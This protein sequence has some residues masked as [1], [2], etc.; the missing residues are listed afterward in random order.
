MAPKAKAPVGTPGPREMKAGGD[1]RSWV[2]AKANHIATGNAFL[3][4]M[5]GNTE[6][7]EA[8]ALGK[9]WGRKWDDVPEQ[10]KCSQRFF[11]FF[12]TYIAERHIISGG[13]N[14][15]DP[16][17]ASGTA[18]GIFNGLLQHTKQQYGTSTREET[19]VRSPAPR[20]PCA[21]AQSRALPA[22]A[23]DQPSDHPPR[24]PQTFLK[25]FEET[26]DQAAWKK[27]IK[28]KIERLCNMRKIRL[29][30]SLD[31]S[32]TEIFLPQ[33]KELCE[34]LA[35]AN[36]KEAAHRKLAI[37]T[38]WLSAGRSS[39]PGFLSY[40]GLKWNS[41]HG[42]CSV[43]AFQSKPNKLK[44]FCTV[45]G[46]DRQCDFMLHFGDYLVWDRGMTV[47]DDEAPGPLLPDLAGDN[48]GTKLSN[49]IKGLQPE[50][51]PGALKKYTDVGCT[52]ASLPPHPTAAGFRP[53]AA[54]TLAIAV[55][56]ELAVHNT[57]HDLTGLSALWEYLNTR[58]SLTI[59]G[60]VVLAGWPPFPYG[61][62]GKGP[63]HPTL[64]ALTGLSSECFERFIDTLFSFAETGG[65]H[66][67]MLLRDGELRIMLRAVLAT[68]IMY[69]EERFLN[70]EMH[71]VLT[72]MR[73]SYAYA[74]GQPI[75]TAHN[76][77]I[78]WGAMINA[79]FVADNLHLTDRRG[80]FSGAEKVIAAVQGLGTS[81]AVIQRSVADMAGRQIA[82]ESKLDKLI[83]LLSTAPPSA[84]APHPSPGPTIHSSP[85]H[86]PG[87]DNTLTTPT[88]PPP[89]PLP[90][91]DI[92]S[93][94]GISSST[95]GPP[96]KPSA[97]QAAYSLRQ[98][99]AGQFFMDCMALG[100]F[101]PPSVAADSRR[102]TDAQRVLSAYSSMAT[103]TE[104]DLLK[105]PESDAEQSR[106]L[107]RR[108]TQ[109]LITRIKASYLACRSGVPS[110]FGSGH[111]Y[112]N[113]AIDNLRDSK[114]VIDRGLF[115]VWR[116]RVDE[117]VEGVEGFGQSEA[118]QEGSASREGDA[119]ACGKRSRSPRLAEQPRRAYACEADGVSEGE[120]DG[121][122][123]VEDPVVLE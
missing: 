97:L 117:G 49:Y 111:F 26:G 57:G 27:S 48:S 63:I 28:T 16:H 109:L 1:S 69:Y 46:A 60:L 81:I 42:T 84:T 101:F 59:P 91:S 100:G 58:V 121:G 25:C 2:S 85:P 112:F 110:T 47:W 30:E 8:S 6:D 34:V 31:N 29:D 114:L 21:C 70:S 98:L 73:E 41:L 12:A 83:S 23:L 99:P 71:T 77:L 102:K 20:T 33:V 66:P 65:R 38:L 68:M 54:D 94:F 17:Y 89:P 4:D 67:P 32:A 55:P 14:K 62:L 74:L 7:E 76:V 105:D 120:G 108:L 11:G 35:Q 50:G 92:R 22:R 5:N 88:Q 104:L 82:L 9:L 40:R 95:R 61:Q 44:M 51:R 80:G 79:R 116:K 53:G 43:E 10:E 87:A 3:T 103:K 96:Q 113:T 72:H 122:G 93:L 52:V 78:E 45:A 115:Q 107:V 118:S 75:E 13:N 19:K 18:V 123:R 64:D 56:A 119:S 15:Q 90:A 106:L 36:H 86:T 24:P 37:F 39:E